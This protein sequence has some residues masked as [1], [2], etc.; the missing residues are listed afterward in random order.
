MK[1]IM[2]TLAAVMM[3]MT[4]S[5]QMYIGGGIGFQSVTP[6]VGDGESSF[7]FAPEIGFSFDE[8]WGAGVA[9]GYITDKGGAYG[10]GA[11]SAF[12][13]SPYVRYTA[14]KWKTMSIFFDGAFDYYQSK[15]FKRTNMALG[16]KP[17]VAVNLNKDLSFVAHMGSLGFKS[18]DPDGDDNNTTVIGFDFSSLNLNFGLY[19]NF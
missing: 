15:N 1:K 5:A 18:F 16:V 3:A 17:G 8:N 4:M 11:E 12:Q 13:F 7:K 6:E 19:Y 10:L 9:I 2:M 14:M